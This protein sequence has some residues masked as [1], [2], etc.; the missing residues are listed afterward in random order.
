MEGGTTKGFYVL[1]AFVFLFAAICRPDVVIAR[2]R[3][4]DALLRGLSGPGRSSSE[5][6][7][8]GS[9]RPPLRL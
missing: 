3:E 1:P 4:S 9:A 7:G 5:T 2:R 8:R 6:R